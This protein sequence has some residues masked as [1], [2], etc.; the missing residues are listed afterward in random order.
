[1]NTFF[2]LIIFLICYQILGVVFSVIL[3]GLIMLI[4]LFI[5]V[6]FKMT[7]EK[8]EKLFEYKNNLILIIIMVICLIIS[9]GIIFFVSELFFEF[10]SYKYKKIS[11]K[12]IVLFLAMPTIFKFFKVKDHLR[13]RLN[14]YYHKKI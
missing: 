13:K 11:S 6:V 3:I 1:M 10:I 8:W 12:L 4:F 2:S 7:E 14:Q 9:L 5:K